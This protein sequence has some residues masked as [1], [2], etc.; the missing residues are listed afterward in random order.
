MSRMNERKYLE[1]V[2]KTKTAQTGSRSEENSEEWSISLRKKVNE[3]NLKVA[4][5]KTIVSRPRERA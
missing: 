2:W 4:K 3:L 1:F 5:S